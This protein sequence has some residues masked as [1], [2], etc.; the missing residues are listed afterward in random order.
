MGSHSTLPIITHANVCKMPLRFSFPFP[1]LKYLNI[2]QNTRRNMT[3]ILSPPKKRWQKLTFCHTY[4]R[5]FKE[6]RL[7]DT[8]KNS[9]CVPFLF[10]KYA[11]TILKLV[12]IFRMHVFQPNFS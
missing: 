10:S 2:Q 6:I 12:S 9:L 11:A 1:I 4:V 8:V 3:I 5:F 7:E